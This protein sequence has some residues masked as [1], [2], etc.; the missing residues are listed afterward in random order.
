MAVRVWLDKDGR[1]LVSPEGN[2]YLSE[3]CCCKSRPTVCWQLY[4][5]TATTSEGVSSRFWAEPVMRDY[6]CLVEGA[7]PPGGTDWWWWYG[8]GATKWVS[9]SGKCSECSVPHGVDKPDLRLVCNMF[10]GGAV[11]SAGLYFSRLYMGVATVVTYK[12][13]HD[14]NGVSVG[15]NVAGSTVVPNW[16]LTA[17]T[18]D[19][20]DDFKYSQVLGGVLSVW[21]PLYKDSA[22]D[23]DYLDPY[24]NS[25]LGST[26]VTNSYVLYSGCQQP[27]P[28][29]NGVSLFGASAYAKQY[30]AT[31]GQ[32][33]MF[34]TLIG[35]RYYAVPD[36]STGIT[37]VSTLVGISVGTMVHYDAYQWGHME[38]SW[39]P[40]G[41]PWYTPYIHLTAHR[42]A[43]GCLAPVSDCSRY[44]RELPH[45]L[46]QDMAPLWREYVW[47]SCTVPLA[48][49][50]D[51]AIDMAL[52][53]I[54]FER[55]SVDFHGVACVTW[56]F[57]LIGEAWDGCPKDDDLAFGGWTR[58]WSSQDTPEY[59][60]F[61][62]SIPMTINTR[63]FGLNT[64]YWYHEDDDALA[65]GS[66]VFRPFSSALGDG[67]AYCITP[68]NIHNFPSW[69]TDMCQTAFE[70]R[71]VEVPNLIWKGTDIGKDF[72]GNANSVAG[73]GGPWPVQSFRINR[74]HEAGA[75]WF[76]YQ[77]AIN[78]LSDIYSQY[79]FIASSPS[80][81]VPG[82]LLNGVDKL[83]ST[84]EYTRYDL[85]GNAYVKTLG[86]CIVITDVGAG[87]AP[88]DVISCQAIMDRPVEVSTY[89]YSGV[90][91]TTSSRLSPILTQVA[92]DTAGLDGCPREYWRG[93]TAAASYYLPR[94][95][96]DPNNWHQLW[97][98]GQH[99]RYC[100]DNSI[101]TY[102]ESRPT[103]G[104][105][106]Y[107]ERF[108]AM[109]QHIP[110]NWYQ[111]PVVLNQI[112][113]GKSD[114]NSVYTQLY[115]AGYK[116]EYHY[117]STVDSS[118]SYRYD[119]DE[120]TSYM[121]RTG[122]LYIYRAGAPFLSAEIRSPRASYVDD[123]T[124]FG[125][126][127][128]YTVCLF[129]YYATV[130]LSDFINNGYGSTIFRESWYVVTGQATETE[131]GESD[132]Y[133]SWRRQAIESGCWA[134]SIVLD[135]L[136]TLNTD[137]G[138]M[139]CML[140]TVVTYDES[141]C[142]SHGKDD[143]SWSY[144]QGVRTETSKVYS[145]FVTT[146][147]VCNTPSF[148]L[149][150][151]GDVWT[152]PGNHVCSAFLLPG[153]ATVMRTVGGYNREPVYD[154]WGT[155]T[156][157]IDSDTMVLTWCA[158]ASIKGGQD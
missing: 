92:I 28:L 4:F 12:V 151:A 31:G 84:Q 150:T 25:R 78:P 18:P 34:L 1:V 21:A 58:L 155:K 67:H 13:V 98:V 142:I 14:E 36:E 54:P 158:A 76:A 115:S 91:C 128:N 94:L 40:D 89:E 24:Y 33:A 7:E 109:N 122:S 118:T 153:T 38:V 116:F 152:P 47:V 26:W 145:D 130:H 134:P 35:S 8:A 138:G 129:D 132:V 107:Y 123:G 148:E 19:D 104:F 117:A 106:G 146:D 114:L 144:N 65:Q 96:V 121:K 56:W 60:Y 87:Y 55:P 27:V 80:R 73:V 143:Y 10:Y 72:Y 57:R 105:P 93:C 45:Y 99:S 37:V 53:G 62:T 39:R 101:I 85:A 139:T 156:N 50:A 51:H 64:G 81:P 110:R 22:I 42:V 154:H 131:Y 32:G 124:R 44:E 157:V 120:Y 70:P 9:F 126:T 90:V 74:I 77:D 48:M 20:T 88:Y 17:V 59:R 95:D 69:R 119:V 2:V 86:P 147:F 52:S 66:T 79:A 100:V 61:E 75:G 140:T 102:N 29:E 63:P 68:L 136:T 16:R 23:A 46:S 141:T 135:W 111:I 49:A 149:V 127:S 71:S 125:D 43:L 113:G 11:S 83:Y 15:Q 137:A 5:A 108:F 133:C 82:T 97:V 103:S 30:Y 6:T 3:E 112:G 41:D